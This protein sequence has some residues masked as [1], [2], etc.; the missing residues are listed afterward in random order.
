MW[1]W[2]V[3]PPA[4]PDV[5]NKLK[6]SVIKLGWNKALWLDVAHHVTIFNRSECLIYNLACYSLICFYQVN[7][8]IISLNNLRSLPSLSA[9]YLMLTYNSGDTVMS[10]VPQ[11]VP[12]RAFHETWEYSNFLYCTTL[13][14][15][16]HGPD[17]GRLHCCNFISVFARMQKKLLLFI[18]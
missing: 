16:A 2:D 10:T 5:I 4:R 8:Q 7:Q 1:R 3:V 12:L 13:T 17:Y 9:S 11:S 18:S 6:Y 14:F 15:F